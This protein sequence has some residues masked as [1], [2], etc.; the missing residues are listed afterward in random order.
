MRPAAQQ[1]VCCSVRVI[2]LTYYNMPLL[3]RS[4]RDIAAWF[5]SA[6]ADP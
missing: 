1:Q 4:P 3:D 6:Q 2:F 5:L